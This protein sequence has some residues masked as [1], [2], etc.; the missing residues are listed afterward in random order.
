MPKMLVASQPLTKFPYFM[1]PKYILTCSQK[2][3]T[4]TFSMSV[5]YQ[6][7]ILYPLFN[8]Q[9]LYYLPTPS[10]PFR[11]LKKFCLPSHFRCGKRIPFISF[12]TQ[13]VSEKKFLLRNIYVDLQISL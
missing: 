13:S 8:T 7:K 12:L 9:F 1:E 3:A 2:L 6:S 10:F 5:E 4:G 11:S